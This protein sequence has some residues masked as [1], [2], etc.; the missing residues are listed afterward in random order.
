M[1]TV[2]DKDTAVSAANT[3]GIATGKQYVQDNLIEFSLVTVAEKDT[4]VTAATLAGQQAVIDNPLL[5]G[6]EAVIPLVKSTIDNL[7]SGWHSL[8]TM[9]EITDLSI[10]DNAKIVWYFDSISESW[11]AYSSNQTTQAAMA[12][13]AISTITTISE[14]SGLWVEK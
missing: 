7:T 9:V 12:A 1:V 5:F 4:A 11:L 8:G 10:F 3:A 6:I 13:S 2:A 14:N